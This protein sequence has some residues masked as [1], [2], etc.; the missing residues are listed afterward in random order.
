MS[1]ETI[2]PG[3]KYDVTVDD[4]LD[5]YKLDK[6]KEKNYAMAANGVCF[7]REQ[8]GL[9]PEI[10][11]KF[12]DDRLRYKGLMQEAQRK[13][14]ETGAKAYQNEVSKYNNFQMAR[15]IQLNSLYGCLLYTSPSPRDQRGSRMPSSA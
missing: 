6:L 3:F 14:Q 9:F 4:L 7:S 5:R 12:F 10:V 11:Q 13:Y 2:V 1:P 15:K 8:K